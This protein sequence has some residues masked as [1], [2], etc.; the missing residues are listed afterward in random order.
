MLVL[1]VTVIVVTAI[2]TQL[3]LLIA[4]ERLVAEW[5]PGRFIFV[6]TFETLGVIT[7][8]VFTTVF[9]FPFAVFLA[10]L[11]PGFSVVAIEILGYLVFLFTPQIGKI[12]IRNRGWTY[13]YFEKVYPE[14]ILLRAVI[15]VVQSK[16]TILLLVIVKLAFTA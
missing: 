16:I 9:E 6:V 7:I 10:V 3:C 2:N 13:T 12:I 15:L 8:S 1:L 14:E 4:A 5:R 11:L